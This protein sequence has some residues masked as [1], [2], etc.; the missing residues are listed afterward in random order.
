MIERNRIVN[1]VHINHKLRAAPSPQPN[2][3]APELLPVKTLVELFTWY[4]ENLCDRYF[5]D[6][7]GLRVS[8]A[9]TDF[10]HLIKLKDKFG[11]EPRNARMAI[12]QIK[13]GGIT[14][15]PGRLDLRRAQELSWAQSII[16]SPDKIV[17]NW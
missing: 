5:T 6:R 7:R 13:S 15:R 1:F 12:D 11:R 10:V 14:L 9:A 3:G 4:S 8:F 2:P 17:A 16:E